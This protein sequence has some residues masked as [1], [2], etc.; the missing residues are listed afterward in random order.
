MAEWKKICCA[1]DFSEPS[2]LAMKDAADLAQRFQ[3]DLTLLH[4]YEE[5][6]A[7]TAALEVPR[8][9][10]LEHAA[11][12]MERKLAGWRSEAEA[13]ASRPVRS[14]MLS[15]N[16]AAEILRFLRQ[17]SFDLLIVGT[18]GRTGIKHFVLGS[19]AER[20]VREADCPVL[21]VRRSAAAGTG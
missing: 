20:V 5:P 9:E 8:L 10:H 1:V 15:G 14:A 12:E 7:A 2:H 6:T 4:V 3:A 17:G 19:V 11:A 18:H 13:G 16:T 21:V